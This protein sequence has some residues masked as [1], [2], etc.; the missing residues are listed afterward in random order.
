MNDHTTTTSSSLHTCDA[1]SC[2][3]CSHWSS[4][5]T[6]SQV[7]QLPNIH[8]SDALCSASK[9]IKTTSS[10]LMRPFARVTGE[11]ADDTRWLSTLI[12]TQSALLSRD[13]LRAADELEVTSRWSVHFCLMNPLSHCPQQ[14]LAAIQEV[15]TSSR[16]SQYQ[17]DCIFTAG[18][19][20]AGTVA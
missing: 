10:Q 11:A 15:P 12:E 6:L 2:T 5:S 17:A 20:G 8:E 13:R 9:P 16:C 1:Q 7:V 3:S 14:S 4:S 18:L 19:A